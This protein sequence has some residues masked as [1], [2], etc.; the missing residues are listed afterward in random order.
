MQP[1][2]EYTLRA[3][4]RNYTPKQ[5]LWDELDSKACKNAANE[6]QSL[7]RKLEDAEAFILELQEKL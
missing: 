7:R 1:T 5:H 6:I 3:M 2:M 4:A